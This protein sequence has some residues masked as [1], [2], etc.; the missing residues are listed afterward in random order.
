[1]EFLQD[2][3]GDNPRAMQILQQIAGGSDQ[4]T[5]WAGGFAQMQQPQRQQPGMQQRK[6]GGE[7]KWQQDKA[8][9]EQKQWQGDLEK[10]VETARTADISAQLAPFVKRRPDDKEAAQLSVD[11]VRSQVL[12]RMNADKDFTGKVQAFLQRKDKQ[13]AMKLI[14]SREKAVIAEVAQ[15]VGRTIFGQGAAPK[16]QDAAQ[17]GQQQ[18][19]QLPARP[20]SRRDIM[21]AALA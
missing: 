21:R 13:G 17:P 15:K 8:Q 2:A 16:Q 7:Q 18:R 6:D 9:F 20:T 19:P 5:K 4:I 12:Q 1:M 3:I 14:A 11:T 10:D